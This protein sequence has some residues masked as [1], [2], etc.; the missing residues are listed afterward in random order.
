MWSIALRTA[1]VF[2]V[3]AIVGVLL[4]APW[5]T[6]NVS[7][8]LGANGEI[9]IDDGSFRPV[10]DGSAPHQLIR[11]QMPEPREVPPLKDGAS[12]LIWEDLWE[13]GTLVIQASDED[14]VGRPG[15]EEFPIGTTAQ[16]VMMFFL[17]ISDMRSLQPMIG[18]I[19]KSLDGKRVRIAGYT[20]PVGFGE[21]ETRFLLVPELGACIHV[22]PP[23]PNQ[24]VYVEEAA[25]TPDMFAPVWVTGTLKASPVATVLADVG[26]QLVDAVAE[27][28]R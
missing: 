19:D 6:N 21:N 9:I 25:G 3:F 13:D 24:I 16:D 18:D 11:Y 7:T 28:Y 23:P 8:L 27:P 4:W 15:M 1:F 2:G 14:R 17:D 10:D 12:A 26:Y 22:P 20:T 5:R